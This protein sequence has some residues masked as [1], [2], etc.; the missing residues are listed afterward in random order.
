MLDF[1]F[2]GHLLSVAQPATVQTIKEE[3]P[4]SHMLLEGM[5]KR[6]TANLERE[7]GQQRGPENRKT[8]FPVSS[9]KEGGSYGSTALHTL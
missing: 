1:Y 9:P 6:P 5:V 2:L 8:K 4:V 3:Q 7:C